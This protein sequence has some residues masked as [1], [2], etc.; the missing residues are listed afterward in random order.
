MRVVPSIDLEGWRAV[1]RVRGR[2]GSGLSLGDPLALLEKLA[3][4]GF[5]KVHI[6]DL[7]GAARGRLS[8][9]A[10]RLVGEAASMGLSV[11]AGG[12]V[13][14]LRDAE[15]LCDAGASE[16][17]VATLWAKAPAEASRVASMTRC[18]GVAAVD[19]GGGAVLVSGWRERGGLGLK[20]ALRSVGSLG[21]RAALVTDVDSEGTL[22]GVNPSLALE[23]R[24]GFKGLLYYAGGVAGE[25]DLELLDEIGVDEAVLGMALYTGRIPWEVAASYA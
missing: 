17:I 11:R 1:K 9:A 21:F 7:D 14:S 4:A 15:M 16:V 18:R 5:R 12:G 25:R 24:R 10:L 6:V 20:E 19:V 23:A 2:P 3:G 13:R 22:S 8:A